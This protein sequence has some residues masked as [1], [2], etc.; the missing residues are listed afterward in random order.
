[1]KEANKNWAQFQKVKCFNNWSNK[2]M[3]VIEVVLPFDIQIQK[4]FLDGFGYFLTK[5]LKNILKIRNVIFSIDSFIILIR[6]IKKDKDVFEFAYSTL[7]LNLEWT[8]QCT[9]TK[10][11]FRYMT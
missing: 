10:S 8:L 9:H 7:N 11:F 2:T 1:M 4:Q 5:N 6:D 3:S